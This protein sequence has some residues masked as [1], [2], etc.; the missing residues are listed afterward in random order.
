[1]IKKITPTDEEVLSGIRAAD[2]ML[3]EHLYDRYLP[4][5]IRLVKR[6]NGSES[7]ARDI[8]QEAVIVLFRKANDEEFRLTSSLQ[9]YILVVCRN[10]W[11][12]KL[13]NHR[14]VELLEDEEN[15]FV[16][17]SQDLDQ[18]IEKSSREQLFFRHFDRL[19]EKCQ[20]ILKWFF[21][22]IPMKE[23]AKKLDTSESYVKKRKFICKKRLMEGIQNDPEFKELSDG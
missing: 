12:K 16:D 8:F 6:N 4:G 5:I 23:I 1:M 20:S 3:I 13:R 22:K 7:E 9:T 14:E 10:L 15:D 18:W 21:D 11:R 19:G 2:R 17:I